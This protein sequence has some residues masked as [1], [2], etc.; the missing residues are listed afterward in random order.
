MRNLLLRA[1]MIAT[2]AALVGIAAAQE[3]KPDSEAEPKKVSVRVGL[4][5]FNE[6]DD[7]KQSFTANIY[8]EAKWRDESLAHK[9]PLEITKPKSEVWNPQFSI[10]N[11]RG[12]VTA[13]LPEI[14]RISPSG[15]VTY[16]QRIYGDF[17]QYLDLKDFPFDTQEFSIQVVSPHKANEID[18][19]QNSELP[20]RIAEKITLP[21]WTI[22]DWSVT[23]DDFRV[24]SGAIPRG[25]FALKF[26]AKRKQGYFIYKIILPLVLIVTM[27]WVV[28]WI[29]LAVTA[30]RI[31]LPATVMLTLI[32]Y[33]YSIDQIIP[34]ISYLTRIDMF[35]LLATVLV[36]FSLIET[37]I[38]AALHER[39]H[40]KWARQLDRVCRVVFPLLFVLCI[41]GTLIW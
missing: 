6:V 20:S 27:S 29:P 14:V 8:F 4:L 38:A 22:N 12:A 23:F 3:P 1:A 7:G 34:Q 39:N 26:V 2:V 40:K 21:D 25:A 35:I 28:F 9:G 16:S 36:Y 17:S 31:G 13:T 30:P 19:V 5:D 15:D 41:V 11:R 37:A 10:V 32:A 18:V 24:E 33:R